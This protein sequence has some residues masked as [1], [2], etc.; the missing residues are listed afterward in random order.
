MKLKWILPALSILLSACTNSLTVPAI[1]T[2]KIPDDI[3]AQQIKEMEFGMFICWSFSTFSGYEWT[4]GVTDVSYF[5]ATGCDTDQ[6]YNS[7]YKLGVK[8]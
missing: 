6:W 5:K 8:Q 4:R 2:E 1:T 3:R 7:R